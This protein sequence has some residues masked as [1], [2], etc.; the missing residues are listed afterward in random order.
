M[1]T[2]PIPNVVLGTLA[3]NI[4]DPGW[5]LTVAVLLVMDAATRYEREAV[6]S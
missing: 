3:W 2:Y 1:K 6:A 5:L 4:K